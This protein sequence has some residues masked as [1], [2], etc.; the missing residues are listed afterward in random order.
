MS[1]FIQDQEQFMP[2]CVESSQPSHMFL[3]TD[4]FLMFCFQVLST[5]LNTQLDIKSISIFFVLLSKYNSEKGTFVEIN[6]AGKCYNP[7]NICI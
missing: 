3:E 1:Q 6:P 7:F 5:L 4:Y 2:Q